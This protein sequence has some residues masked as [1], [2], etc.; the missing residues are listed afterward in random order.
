MRLKIFSD[1]LK[2]DGSEYD[3]L[4]DAAK[5]IKGVPGL[6]LEIG[7]RRAG[8]TK[9]IIDSL[10]SNGDLWR[11]VVCLD[12]YG[13]IPYA[14]EEG[15]K[16]RIDY[17]NEMRGDTL[18]NLYRYVHGKPVH[19]YLLILEDTEYF[20]RFPDGYPTYDTDK[21]LINEYAL[22][23]FDGPHDVRS[24]MTEIEFFQPRTPVGGMWVFDDIQK[25]P[26]EQSI[27][28]RLFGMGWKLVN[29]KA[30]KASYVKTR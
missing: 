19:V 12:P 25:Y 13:N 6:C 4:C 21:R 27:E 5:T 7:T 8:S 30:P 2:T 16:V 10:L 28:A 3:I 1:G 14:T 23:F 29:K 15:Q 24:L 22:V 18:R 11:S 9:K 26:H 20:K 17:T